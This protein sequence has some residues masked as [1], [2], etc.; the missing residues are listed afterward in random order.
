M[1]RYKKYPLIKTF[2]LL[3]IFIFFSQ[4]IPDFVGKIY[5]QDSPFT[6]RNDTLY[7]I[8][9]DGGT[10]VTQTTTLTNKTDAI[11]IPQ[12]SLTLHFSDITDVSASTSKG[13]VSVQTIADNGSTVLSPNLDAYPLR[14]NQ[15]VTWTL[16]YTTKE[17]T[18]KEGQIWEI[19]IPYK[20]KYDAL[21]ESESIT[22]TVPKSLGDENYIYPKPDKREVFDTSITYTFTNQPEAGKT[23]NASFGGS[24][25]Y[26]VTLSYHLENT[27]EERAYTEIALPPDKDNQIVS[28]TDIS[29]RPQSIS[30]DSD[31]N[32]LA[33]YELDPRQK[34]D[35]TL[36]GSI[37]IYPRQY[38]FQNTLEVIDASA[39]A[40]YLKED[41]YWEVNNEEIRNKAKDLTDE[42][43]STYENAQSI[44]KF[45]TR[46]L[47]YNM[48]KATGN[49]ERLGA[50]QALHNPDDA[51]C[52]EFADLYIALARASGIPAR[53]IDGFAYAPQSEFKIDSYE[54]LH[55]WVEIYIPSMGWIQI[56]PTWSSA[57]ST[58]ELF[59]QFDA[60]HIT[61]VT[62][63]LS[64]Q[65]PYPAGSYKTKEREV[66]DVVISVTEEKPLLK[67]EVDSEI[68]FNQKP[69]TLFLNKGQLLL[70]NT[71][72]TSAYSLEAV[73][74]AEEGTI[75]CGDNKTVILP[76]FSEV[77]IPLSLTYS[78]FEKSPHSL[79]KNNLLYM[80]KNGELFS[81]TKEIS[82][83]Y[84][85]FYINFLI[86]I[87][88]LLFGFL[89]FYSIIKIVSH[90]DSKKSSARA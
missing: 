78:S 67:T 82:I 27:T 17:I 33:R 41:R 37:I 61:F 32:Y 68:I 14:T 31:G 1:R 7:T 77:I 36:T 45:V 56:D 76:P 21:E 28:Y 55:E 81:Q 47:K 42:N 10:R 20:E 46:Y 62:K 70:K 4:F 69:V 64:S 49:S 50:L 60:K 63:G 72:T 23:I 29:P 44:F 74:M 24:Q 66:G 8:I 54:V 48:S 39:F 71:G 40:Q 57:P 88:I 90:N 9:D 80:N 13:A 2:I 75:N 86:P 53:E 59:T 89:L 34:I 16:S 51:I 26:S 18:D 6:V 30:V 85:Y 3:P 87:G 12:Y 22:V 19:V 52:M 58:I 38:D 43:K 5:A 84:D 65:T 35:V 25:T 15:D 73:C 83:S 11:V 79:I